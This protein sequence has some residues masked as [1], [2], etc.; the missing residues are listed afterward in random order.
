MCHVK[1]F[2]HEL[3]SSIIKWIQLDV[4]KVDKPLRLFYGLVSR[5]FLLLVSSIRFK[6]AYFHTCYYAN[7]ICM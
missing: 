3:N 5:I 2:T 1:Y 4:D 6:I 7:V